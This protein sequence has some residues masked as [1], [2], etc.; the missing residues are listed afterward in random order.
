MQRNGLPLRVTQRCLVHYFLRQV[1]PAATKVDL[2][3]A[4]FSGMLTCTPLGT[5]RLCFY[6]SGHA[7]VRGNEM[8]DKHAS[9]ADITTSIQLHRLEALRSLRYLL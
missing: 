4:A 2:L 1:E 5:K 3:R 6:S 9:S 7:G 8:A